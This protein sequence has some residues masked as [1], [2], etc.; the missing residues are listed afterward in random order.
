MIGRRVR[1]GHV[2]KGTE[3][4]ERKNTILEVTEGEVEYL[5]KLKFYFISNP[6][7]TV[8]LP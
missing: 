7:P 8:L 4:R 3:G 1:G 2:L 5:I 6:M